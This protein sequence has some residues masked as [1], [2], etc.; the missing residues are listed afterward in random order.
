MGANCCCGPKPPSNEQL[1]EQLLDRQT[2]STLASYCDNVYNKDNAPLSPSISSSYSSKHLHGNVPSVMND[3][4]EDSDDDPFASPR[5]TF[6]DES[7]LSIKSRSSRDFDDR[8]S[9][10]SSVSSLNG[11][12]P[13]NTSVEKK[14]T[15]TAF[16]R[17]DSYATQSD[18]KM[19]TSRIFSR[20]EKNSWGI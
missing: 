9:Y 2:G 16:D 13:R 15:G 18:K 1:K 14:K 8:L 5:R 19:Y 17:D 7:E 4:D 12:T 11:T 10:G 3:D 6:V 20:K